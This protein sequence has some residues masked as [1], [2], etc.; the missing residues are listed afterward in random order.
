RPKDGGYVP[1]IIVVS[2]N[3][4]EKSHI[5]GSYFLFN[6]TSLIPFF[7]AMVGTLR[8]KGQ[9]FVIGVTKVYSVVGLTN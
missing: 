7:P 1:S 3:L 8:Y 2:T 5:S 9:S 6:R 4:N